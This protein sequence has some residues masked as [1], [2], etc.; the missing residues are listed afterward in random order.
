MSDQDQDQQETGTYSHE[1]RLCLCCPTAGSKVGTRGN[2][3]SPIVLV[4]EGADATGLKSGKPFMGPAAKLI[5]QSWPKDLGLD[6]EDC[7]YTTAVQ[8]FISAK[9]PNK[10]QKATTCCRDR[11]FE[12]I[13]TAPRKIILAFGKQAGISL[14]RDDNFKIMTQRGVVKTIRHPGR[15]GETVQLMH[16]LHPAQLLRGQ[17]N[18]KQFQQ[19]LRRAVE[20]AL[21]FTGRT[22]IDPDYH[23]LSSADQIQE[24]IDYIKEINQSKGTPTRIGTDIETTG[25]SWWKDRILCVGLFI[26][27]IDEKSDNIGYVIDW[28]RILLEWK[29]AG[30][31][32][33]GI[34]QA[35][36]I[37][38]KELS[39]EDKAKSPM[40]LKL[41]ELLELSPEIANYIW[42][43]GKFDMKFLRTDG[44]KARID[45]DTYGA[46]YSLDERAGSHGLE[47]IAKNHLNAPDYKDEIQQY[48][49]NKKASYELIPKPVLWKYLARDVKNTHDAFE[50]LIK[51]VHSDV[52]DTKNYERCLKPYMRMLTNVEM[53]GFYV[54]I[55]H[56]QDND[57]WLL[58]EIDAAQ[59]RVSEAAGEY[60]NPNS[61]IQVAAHLY[62]RLGL[63]L[64][65]KTP[66]GTAKEILD[67]LYE[68]TK[69]P[70]LK[71]IRDYRTVVKAHSTYIKAVYRFIAPD[72]RIHSTYDPCRTTTGRLGSSEPNLQNIPRNPRIRRMYRSSLDFDHP[73]ILVE[74]DYNTAELRGLAALSRDK[75]LLEIFL[76]PTRSLHDEVA[77]EMYGPG[78]NGDQRIR[79]KAINFGIPYGRE[80]FSIAEEFDITV[81]EAQRLI[82]RW[83]A[84]FPEATAFL[85][86]CREAPTNGQTLITAFGRK[87]RPGVVSPELLHGLKNEFANF[88]MQSTIND[89][90]LQASCE[91]EYELEKLDSYIVNLIHD[92]TLV[93]APKSAY[94]E[95]K[96]VMKKHMEGVPKK[97]IDT[98]IEFKVDFKAG[99]H[100]GEL[101]KEEKFELLLD[102]G[103]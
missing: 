87:R 15:D 53:H 64:K 32:I 6:I 41:K 98:P 22:Y 29:N 3:K 42:Q 18:L 37:R 54:D 63:K 58:G 2:W 23:Q 100:W 50:V 5:V 31:N 24:L 67:K 8:C 55:N 17:G 83:F 11:L 14:L 102:E 39:D 43:N 60:L 44:I 47:E 10:Q 88:F 78:F 57:A 85:N 96:A 56:L 86:R 35:R 84:T 80:A 1:P 25:L 90:T 33:A 72:G 26:H 94:K 27:G 82:N 62:D 77:T 97:W 16:L 74:G 101:I 69:H 46:S 70:V 92:A 49:P 95:V 52:H 12:Q 73:R 4:G 75:V 76:D 66:D 21:G 7:F 89:F 20:M 45:E 103:R 13:G 59:A 9:D 30:V 65:G 99:T 48:L 61:P 81:E 19:D 28:D 71:A 36:C 79:A 34:N 91:M 68:E 51:K 93:D 38:G 40:Y